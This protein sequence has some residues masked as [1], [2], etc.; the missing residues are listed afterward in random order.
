LNSKLSSWLIGFYRDIDSYLN[1]IDILYFK[2]Y[3][4]RQFRVISV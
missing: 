3:F 2:L 4:L 1:N